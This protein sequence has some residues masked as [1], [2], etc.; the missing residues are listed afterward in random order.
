MVH[1]LCIVGSVVDQGPIE[2][3]LVALMVWLHGVDE[4]I[5]SRRLLLLL[6]LQKRLYVYLFSIGISTVVSV[7]G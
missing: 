3:G 5:L 4:I 1:G 7:V 6:C 2:F